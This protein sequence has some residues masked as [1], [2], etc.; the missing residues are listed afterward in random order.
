MEDLLTRHK[1]ELRA[2]QGDITRLKKS[3]P[4]GDKK[5]KKE[6]AVDIEKLENDMKQKHKEEIAHF[7]ENNG[8]DNVVGEEKVDNIQTCESKK[9]RAQIRREKKELEAREREKRIKDGTPK[10]GESEQEVE[11]AIIM[12]QLSKLSLTISKTIPDGN[13]LYESVRIQLPDI[14]G[15]TTRGVREVVAKH[16]REHFSDFLPFCT[17]EDGD[18]M[19][20]D[21]FNAYC[22][23][24][25]TSNDWGGLPELRAL[26]DIYGIVIH[27]YQAFAPLQEIVGAGVDKEAAH[28][29]HLSFHRKQYGLGAHYN[30]VVNAS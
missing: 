18:A 19:S 4:K 27:V 8:N 29:V 7:E 2:L 12:E 24:M 17:T 1:K 13:C 14:D 9:S 26:A 21:D 20:K 22:E 6:V 15:L 3:I 5:K 23:R 30:A 25:A 11:E 10:E 16:M 28:I